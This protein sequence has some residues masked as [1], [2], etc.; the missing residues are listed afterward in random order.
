[1]R[2]L[3]SPLPPPV[4][5]H[6]RY[7]APRT[8]PGSTP[9]IRAVPEMA[10]D[11]AA[12]GGLPERCRPFLCAIEGA[13]VSGWG[14]EGVGAGVVGPAAAAPPGAA[15]GRRDRAGGGGRAG[16]GLVLWREGCCKKKQHRC[17]FL[18]RRR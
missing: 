15:A 13:R 4:S 3:V 11:E 2:L 12:R 10:R 6:R 8:L 18:K 9:S 5:C 16:G 17:W 1:M 7:A 14:A